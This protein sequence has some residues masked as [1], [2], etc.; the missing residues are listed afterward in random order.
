MKTISEY[1]ALKKYNDFLDE[2]YGEVQIG[3][4]TYYTSEA[5]KTAMK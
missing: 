3:A 4:Y 2:V 5:L 1:E